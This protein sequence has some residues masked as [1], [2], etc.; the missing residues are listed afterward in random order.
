MLDRNMESKMNLAEQ[1]KAHIDE[2]NA[3][4]LADDN[5]FVENI[6]ALYNRER[7]YQTF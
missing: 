1:M 7:F 3:K 6:S 2:Q 5:S 4:A